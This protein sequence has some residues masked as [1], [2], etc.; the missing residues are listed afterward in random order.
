MSVEKDIRYELL[1]RLC[2]NSTGMCKVS[3]IQQINQKA[4]ILMNLYGMCTIIGT[5]VPVLYGR[6]M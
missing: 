6:P 4:L 2:P 3:R 5:Y 1:A